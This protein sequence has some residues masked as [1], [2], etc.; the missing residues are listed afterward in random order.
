MVTRPLPTNVHAVAIYNYFIKWYVTRP[1]PTNVQYDVASS[2][3][4]V[5]ECKR[6]EPWRLVFSPFICLETDGEEEED[7]WQSYRERGREGD[8]RER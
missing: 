3:A 4:A 2:T 7:V 6:T 8:I 1:L 5:P